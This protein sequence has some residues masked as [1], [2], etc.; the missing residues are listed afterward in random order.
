MNIAIIGCGVYSMAMA[1]RLSK[2]STNNIKVWSED[3][4]KVKDFEK[5]HKIPSIFK[6]EVFS[7]NIKLYDKYYD[8]LKDANIIFI[9]VSSKFVT[10]VL[11]ELKSYYKKDMMIVVGTKGFNLE[12]KEFFSKTIKKELKTDKIGV[13]AGPS[14]AIDILNDQMLAL[15]IATKKRK[16]YNTILDIYK[17]TRTTFDKTSD[18]VCVEL[19]SVL[20]NIYAIGAGILEGNGNS[21]TNSG[22]YLTNVMNGILHILYMY[23][24]DEYNLLTYACLGDTIMTCSNKESR[25]YTYGT[26]LASKKKNDAKSYLEKTTVEGYENLKVMYEILKK[27]K[28][29]ANILY[30][31]YDIVYNNKDAKALENELVK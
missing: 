2:N 11:K 28:I 13:I 21:T 14:F 20:K 31:I 5:N 27:K 24:K 17:D 12:N 15:T 25:N 19:S 4:K 9:M 16:I 29:K 30:A 1:K 8:V 6:D 3:S 22:I 7:K 18:T 26:K 23:N 10:P